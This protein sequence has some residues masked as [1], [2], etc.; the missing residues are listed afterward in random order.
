MFGV[1]S[2][3]SAVYRL[4]GKGYAYVGGELNNGRINF[5][6]R[7]LG[8]FIILNDTIPPAIRPIYLNAQNI[9]LKIRDNLSGIGRFYA[10]ING[11]WLLLHYDAKTGILMSEKKNKTESLKG[12]VVVEVTDLAGNKETFKSKIL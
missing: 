8:E 2:R 7:E 12:D 1:W 9:R 11:Q 4:V 6:T 10:T 3:Q 5:S